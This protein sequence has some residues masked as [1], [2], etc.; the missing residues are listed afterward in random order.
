[1]QAGEVAGRTLLDRPDRPTAIFAVNDNTAIGVM[2]AA[3]ALGL[4]IPDDLSLVGYN[5]IPIVSRLPIP[6]TTVR[7][8]FQQIAA[9][10]SSSCTKPAT[11]THPAPSSPRRRSSHAS[12]PSPAHAELPLRG[13]QTNGQPAPAS[14]G[15]VKKAHLSQSMSIHGGR[16]QGSTSMAACCNSQQSPHRHHRR[17]P[18][19]PPTGDARIDL[20]PHGY[21]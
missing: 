8:P 4:R 13:R 11:T 12:Q 3:H 7:V 6:L 2:A 9:A 19:A 17:Q 20:I 10:H 21:L 18:S 14:A 16:C 15:A 5:D 1:M